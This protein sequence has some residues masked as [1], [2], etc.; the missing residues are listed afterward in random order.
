M[1][2]HVNPTRPDRT[3]H[4]PYNFIPLPEKVKTIAP[5]SL[6][7][8]DRYEEG[9]HTGWIDLTIKTETPLYIRCGPKVGDILNEAE[10]DHAQLTRKH[11]YRQD[12]F[13]H[14][15][16][17]HPVIPGSSIRG[18]IRSLVEILSFGKIQ[19]FTDKQLI[20]RAVGDTS[21]LGQ[22]YR[23]S[24]LGSNQAPR[25]RQ[26]LFEYPLPRL[27]GGY[28]EQSGQGWAIRPAQ[29]FCGESF[30]HIED[31]ACD[32]WTGKAGT[33]IPVFVR[34]VGRTQPKRS[35]KNL[36]LNLAYINSPADIVPAVPGTSRHSGFKKGVLVHSGAMKGKHMHCVIY[37]KDP[38]AALIPIPPSMWKLYVDD[39]ELTRGIPTRKLKKNGAPLFYLVDPQDDLV[40]FGPTMMFRLPYT[41]RIQDFIPESIRG[42]DKIDIPDS[43]FGSVKTDPPLKSRVFFEDLCWDGRGEPFFSNQGLRSPKILSG[44][45]PT[46][47]QHYLTQSK[48]DENQQLFHYDSSPQQTCIRGQKRYWHKRQADSFE[49]GPVQAQD[50][51]HTVIRPVEKGTVFKGRVRFENLSDLEL[52]ALLST[53]QLP[54]SKRHH[55]GMGKP[56]G[57][58][59][60]RI[61]A[62]LH[63]TA[64]TGA[65]SRYT[66]LY[67]DD[68][69]LNLGELPA[70][71][72]KK[73]EK[74]AKRKFREAMV[75]HYKS[76]TGSVAAGL[77]DIPRLQALALMLEW[78]GAPS[79]NQ[80][81]Y[82]DLKEWRE[83]RVL[84]TPRSVAPSSLSSSSSQL[85]SDAESIKNEIGK[86]IRGKGHISQVPGFVER[87]KN[88]SNEKARE[89]C[90]KCL[91]D[92]LKR[93]KVWTDKKYKRAGWREELDKLL[94]APSAEN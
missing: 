71:Q 54:S 67:T 31:N 87:I 1:V 12:F 44:P 21:S 18:M 81:A 76:T 32:D 45:K 37:E 56:L 29:K 60:V 53:L 41:R 38:G 69:N 40:F 36:T 52:G 77:W 65:E 68:R 49:K 47:F 80:T 91:R 43:I 8:H 11:R 35:R 42:H 58:G 66:S 34:P 9:R 25:P 75:R 86:N 7:R 5:E 6:P 15:Q 74:E 72:N 2:R 73:V 19:W 16:P 78:D 20:Y 48:P 70:T 30:I 28:L 26:M 90:A 62:E 10:E 79:S 4:A 55:L 63:D 51:Q 84:P 14:G 17:D 23:E 24:M 94:P 92:K 27:R 57:M 59:S 39:R 83:R 33:V 61:E 3:S 88:L 64:R 89:C 93:I 50:T 13:H 85:G 82:M 46:A 22:Q